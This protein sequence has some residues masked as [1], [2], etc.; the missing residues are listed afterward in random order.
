MSPSRRTL[1]KAFAASSALLSPTLLTACSNGGSAGKGGTLS[2]GQISDSVAFFPLFIA[3]KR[4][5]F[6]D[7]GLSLG[8]RPRLGTGAKVAAALKSGSI[9]IGAGVMTDV[10]NLAENDAQ[11]RLTTSLVTEYYVDIVVKKGF[12]TQGSS[13]K[14]KTRA[15][16]GKKIG[17]TGPGSGTEALVNYLFGLAG[18]DPRTDATLV[19]LGAV[20]SAALGALKAGRVD[21][22]AFFQ[23][24]GQ[25]AEAAGIG[26]IYIS[27]AAGDVP[28]LTG[29]LHGVAFTLS[30]VLKE[31]S[32]EIASFQSAIGRSLKFIAGDASEVR[33][34]LGEYLSSAPGP[35]LDALVPILRKESPASAAVAGKSY[36][37]AR[38]FHV[39]S[40]LVK[41]APSYGKLVP[42]AFR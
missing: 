38:D 17:I 1:L 11:A 12:S 15:L 32:A 16:A 6:K 23:P 9:D 37:I 8:D 13:L 19:N 33:D 39:D 26:D 18:L 42:E 7:E 25:Q 30:G 21:A 24:I 10:L 2:I 4:G 27:P 28:S 31:K 5:F 14:E 29:A 22:L 40:G 36:G 35:A 34:L 20:S 41:S 3:E